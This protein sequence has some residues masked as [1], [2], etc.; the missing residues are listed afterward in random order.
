MTA[1][2][3]AADAF[4]GNG[5]SKRFRLDPE[6]MNPKEQAANAICNAITNLYRKKCSSVAEERF[7]A[8][9]ENAIYVGSLFEKAFRSS[10]PTCAVENIPET[11]EWAKTYVNTL[12]DVDAIFTHPGIYEGFAKQLEIQFPRP[13]S[14]ARTSPPVATAFGAASAG[15]GA[16]AGA[17]APARGG[18]GGPEGLPILYREEDLVPV[19]EVTFEKYENDIRTIAHY[20]K[21]VK[22]SPTIYWSRH[23]PAYQNNQKVSVKTKNLG[24]SMARL[25]Q[26]MWR[27]HIKDKRT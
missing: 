9:M 27:N 11:V 20:W 10:S 4:V 18:A 26:K 16:G 5:P 6:Y 14:S 25:F 17:G 23:F 2:I 22:H 7:N 3:R 12:I 1:P 19:E 15:A 8:S 13:D 24:Y 21:E